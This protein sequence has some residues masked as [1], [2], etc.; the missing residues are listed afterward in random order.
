MGFLAKVKNLKNA[1]KEVKASTAYMFCS[2]LQKCLTMLTMPL[3]TRLLTT[4]DYGY[5]TVYTSTM[6]VMIIFTSLQLPYGSFSKAMIKYEKDRDGY[7]SSVCAICTFLTLLYYVVY[8]LFKSVFN[9]FLDLPESLM[10]IMGIEMMM[11]TA[12]QFWMGKQRFEYHYKLVVAITLITSIVSVGVS[13]AAVLAVRENKGVIKVLC[14]AGVLTA[15]GT[16]LYIHE[17]IKG[18]K[19]F[20][21][22][23]WKYALSFNIPLVPYYLSQVI[24]N[25]SDRLMINSLR[26]RG[27]AAKYNVAYALALVLTFVLN[28]VNNSYVPWLYRKIKN[29]NTGA[30]RGISLAIAGCMAFLIL[31]VVSLGPELILIFGGRKYVGAEWV[32]PPVS[33]SLLLLLYAQ[34]FINIEFFYEQKYK[35]VGASVLAAIVNV[36]LN[37]FCIR[38]YGYVAAGYTTLFSYFIF[39]YCNYIS[40]KKLSKDDDCMEKIYDYKALLILLAVF[41]AAGAVLTLLYPFRWV[42]FTLIAAVLASGFVFRNKLM[43]FFKQ[44]KNTLKE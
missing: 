19:P 8:I 30:N 24:F 20:R 33:L 32:I 31:G 17:L 28:A 16:I 4:E 7:I 38:R 9:R 43:V 1:S 26:G 41:M 12:Q 22:E 37:Y 34:F 3:F 11:T 35:L 10:L 40:M 39:A 25:Q 6:A 23:Y 21:K 29:R 18:K 15:A 42:R 14:S 27:D 5:S 2:I 44:Y 36:V 13:L